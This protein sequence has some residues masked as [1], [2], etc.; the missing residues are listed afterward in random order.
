MRW[1]VIADGTYQAIVGEITLTLRMEKKPRPGKKYCGFVLEMA[2][3]DSVFYKEY[4]G[5]L[6]GA[7]SKA[8]RI[9]LDQGDVMMRFGRQRKNGFRGG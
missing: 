5:R 7:K 6:D 1:T 3:C 2:W 4:A 8:C 9:M